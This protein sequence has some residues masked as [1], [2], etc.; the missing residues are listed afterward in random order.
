MLPLSIVAGSSSPLVIQ[1]AKADDPT[2]KAG[3]DLSGASTFSA[4]ARDVDTGVVVDFTAVAALPTFLDADGDVDPSSMGRV[5]MTYTTTSFDAGTYVVQ[6]TFL[7]SSGTTHT[8][9]SDGTSLKLR[10]VE[11]IA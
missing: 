9:P 2:G 1:L 5:E 11:R 3:I 6:I 4:K 8:Y 7:D 10:V